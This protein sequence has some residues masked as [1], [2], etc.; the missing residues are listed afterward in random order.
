MNPKKRHNM[1][2]H[3][4]SKETTDFQILIDSEIKAC[5]A[6]RQ[7]RK[8]LGNYRGSFLT[9]ELMEREKFMDI[10]IHKQ[11]KLLSP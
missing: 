5:E 11:A 1:K 3:L 8:E 6:L 9:Y 10:L 2:K 7:L 4:N